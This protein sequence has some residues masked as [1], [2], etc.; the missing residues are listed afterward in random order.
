MDRKLTEK[1]TDFLLG[2]RELM[3]KHSVIMYA[4]DGHVCFEVDYSGED[5]PE[6]PVT[7]PD[8]LIMRLDIDEFIEHN[9]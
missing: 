3:A 8:D 2:L 5:D 6:E 7:L 9:S 1:E 4:E